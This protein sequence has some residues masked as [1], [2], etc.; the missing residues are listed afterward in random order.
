M[1]AKENVVT[2]AVVLTHRG[3]GRVRNLARFFSFVFIFVSLENF[4]E[5]LP[6]LAC[7]ASTKPK[8]PWNLE[9]LKNV[10]PLYFKS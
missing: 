7:S 9:T 2:A 10:R 3:C 8:N 5:D 1:D 6:W 4:L